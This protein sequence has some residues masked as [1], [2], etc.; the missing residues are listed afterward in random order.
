[1]TI[2][3]S[4]T[5]DAAIADEGAARRPPARTFEEGVR[6]ARPMPVSTAEMNKVEPLGPHSLVWKFYGDNRQ[7]LGFQRVAGTENCIEQLAKGVEDH[8]VI[9]SDFKGRAERTVPPIMSTVYSADPHGWGRKVRDFHRNIKGTV[10]SD[11]SSYHAMNPE[12][13][14]WAHAT[15]VDQVIYVTDTFIRRLS[16][17]EKAQLFEESKRWY[18]LYGVDD[19]AEPQTYEEFLTYWD[20]MLDRFVPTKTIVYA[21]GY[22]RKGLPRPRQ[23]PPPVWRVASVPLNALLRTLVIGTLPQQMRDVCDLTWN[24]RMQK[25]FD[26]MTAAIR[27]LNPIINRLPVD[28]L[29]TAWAAEAWERTGV[30]PRPINN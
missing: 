8:S 14:Y 17:A 7:I 15:F 6:E 5:P 16:H 24:R 1:M 27:A 4:T 10:D 2:A 13:F 26:R 22:L 9:F 23:V 29:Y 3:D 11:G 30:D 20:G 19:R 25:R 28:K 12:L 18:A 21:T